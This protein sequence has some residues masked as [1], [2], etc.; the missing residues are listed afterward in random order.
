MRL[1]LTIMYATIDN[2]GRTN[3]KLQTRGLPPHP[4]HKWLVSDWVVLTRGKDYTCEPHSLV[5]QARRKAR[6]LGKNLSAKIEGDEVRIK[7][8]N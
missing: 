4:W 3:R 2:M 8:R 6:A 7:C 1:Q 5:M